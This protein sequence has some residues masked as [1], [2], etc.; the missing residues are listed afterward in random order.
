MPDFSTTYYRIA[1][2]NI[3]KLHDKCYRGYYAER[4]FKTVANGVN[5]FYPLEKLEWMKQYLSDKNQHIASGCLECLCS[6][7][8]NMDDGY[9]LFHSRIED[10]V[11]SGKVIDLAEKYNKPE[12]LLIYMDE[13]HTYINRII[14]ALKKT[15]H[16]D[17]LT[18]LLLSDN[19]AIVKAVDKITRDL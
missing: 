7:G 16:E 3:E 14:I 13:N 9:D 17:Y 5:K 4:L 6:H 10:K 18:T 15:H 1:E 11:F 19:D 8:Y 12:I 2:N